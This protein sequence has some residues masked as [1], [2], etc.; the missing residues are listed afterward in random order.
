[1]FQ[2]GVD[3]HQAILS[4]VV[5]AKAGQTGVAKGSEQPTALPSA[6]AR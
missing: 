4:M 3:H 6:A 1:M 5:A 2:T